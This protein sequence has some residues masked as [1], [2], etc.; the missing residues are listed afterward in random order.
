MGMVGDGGLGGVTTGVAGLAVGKR[1]DEAVIQGRF[2]IAA[3]LDREVCTAR[4]AC[5]WASSEAR[6]A[7]RPAA[8]WTFDVPPRETAAGP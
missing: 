5:A 8:A 4:R 2:A 3:P 7:G 1:S 6:P